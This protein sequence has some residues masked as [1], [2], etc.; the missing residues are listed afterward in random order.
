MDTDEEGED[1]ASRVR[2]PTRRRRREED[3]DED[4]EASRGSN[5]R[6]S[7]GEDL[8]HRI[9]ELRTPATESD[10]ARPSTSGN[11]KIAEVICAFEAVMIETVL[12]LKWNVNNIIFSSFLSW[13]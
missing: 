7:V 9:V 11:L 1:R 2:S 12:L 10:D 5:A 4:E 8:S 3:D 6:H 13:A